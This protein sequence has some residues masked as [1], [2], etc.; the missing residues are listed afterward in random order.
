MINFK[1]NSLPLMAIMGFAVL[2]CGTSTAWAQVSLGAAQNFG[3]LAGTT[4]T[5]T[6]LTVITG[7]VG[8]SPGTAITGFPPGTVSGG[9]L[10][11]NDGLTVQAQTDLTTAYNALA[12]MTQTSDKSGQDLGG[13]TLTPGVYHFSSSAQLTGTLILDAQGNSNALFIFQI[14]STLTTATSAVVTLI[15]SANKNNVYWQIGSSATLGTYT[16]FSGHLV[17]LTSITATTGTNVS[18]NLLA[19]NGAVTLDTNHISMSGVTAVELVSFKAVQ[20]DRG[21]MLEWQTGF[22]A[23][24]LGFNLYRQEAGK[25]QLITNQLVAGSALT[26]GLNTV[27]Q[28]GESYVWWDKSSSIDTLY[29]LEDVDLNGLSTW[30]GPFAVQ[31]A[32]ANQPLTTAKQQL[33]KLLSQLGSNDTPTNSS[34]PVESFATLAAPA[35]VAMEQ[36]KTL[37]FL[38]S[39]SGRKLSF[40]SQSAVKISV[41]SEGWYR[42]TQPELIRA[43]LN[44]NVDPKLLRLSVDG[45]EVP[46]KVSINKNGLFDETSAI[47]FYGQALDTPSTNTRTY[48]LTV[49]SQAGMRVQTVMGEGSPSSAQGF[50]FTVERKDRTIYFSSLLNGESENF[51]GAVITTYPVNQELLLPNV[52]FST[53]QQAEIEVVLQ[54]VTKVPHRVTVQ[55]NGLPLGDILFNGQQQGSSK[56]IVQH[57]LLKEGSNIVTL[58]AINSS[59]DVNLVEH[60]RLTY[61]HA[62]VADDNYLKL[63]VNDGQRVTLDGFTNRAI[64]VF[65]VSNENDVKELN[66]EINQSKKGYSI[67]VAANQTAVKGDGQSTLLALTDDTA[68]QVASIKMNLPSNW[69]SPIEGADLVIITAREFFPALE[70]LRM[71]RQSEGYT[72]A[73]VD[74]EDLYDE[75]SF[76]QKSPQAIKD[77]LGF[78]KLNWKIQPAYLLLAADA[79]YDAKNY[80]RMGDFDIVPTKLIDT[81]DMETAS[82]DWL[83]DFNN[84]GI[85]DLYI[86]RLPVR[87]LEQASGLINKILGYSRSAASRSVLLVSDATDEFNFEQASAQLRALLPTG[88]PVLEI[89]R[90]Q[91]DGAAAKQQLLD[92]INQGQKLVNYTGHGSVN[93]WRGNLLTS[94]DAITLTN[95]ERLPLFVMMTCLNGYFQDPALDGLG[96]SLLKAEKGGAVA[97]WAS[98]GMTNAGEQ[99]LLNQQFYRLL[100]D[101]RLKGL[102]LGE[103]AM[104]AKSAISDANVRRTWVLLGDPTLRLQ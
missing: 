98:T 60:M 77:F 71:V 50:S 48:W 22:E 96:E 19:R 81:A 72:V 79:S 104:K 84:D 97:V 64:R 76:G 55:L 46:M 31:S 10:H 86:G 95:K 65:E 73:L 3:V 100:F 82:D 74:I 44:P 29:W 92:S 43:G 35:G 6:G 36:S 94:Q 85:S 34:R 49:A 80:L 32:T 39:E 7:D 53:A 89:K 78:A 26:A 52:N 17:A 14:G 20:Y 59:S 11:S 13:L 62:F 103:A 30:H 16:T 57:S 2:F 1:R 93:L 61:Q 70:P 58:A 28:S 41:T 69:R 87:T 99:A 88:F 54:G 101:T 4:V 23:D 12:G 63:C 5:N 51:F 9:T 40:D 25:R 56:F 83:A 18:G 8:V 75:F 21:T 42:V 15:N 66:G 33:A 90:G 45:R 27:L 67:T 24:N 102:S 47:E 68:K 37:S 38:A 91:V